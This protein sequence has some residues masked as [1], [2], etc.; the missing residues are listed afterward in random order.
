M[1]HSSK[2]YDIF[3]SHRGPEAK[4]FC[5]FL[6]E[7][8]DRA[9]VHAF[10]DELDLEVGAPETAWTTMQDTLQGAR[11]TMP[12]ISRGY[13]DSCWCLDELVLMMQSPAKVMPIFFGVG[14]SKDTLVDLL[15]RCAAL[16]HL[17]T[18][19]SSIITICCTRCYEKAATT[20]PG[21]D[22]CCL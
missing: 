7:S 19:G 13:M 16:L 14:P 10:V 20:V 3:L 2:A 12:V 17:H 18:H 15:F 9:G 8:L 4:D 11:Y 1:E 6:K 22:C 21:F 5:A